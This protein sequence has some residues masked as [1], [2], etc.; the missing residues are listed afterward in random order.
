MSLGTK[1]H[2]D[3]DPDYHRDLNVRRKKTDQG[4]SCTNLA[5]SDGFW[6]S[7]ICVACLFGC[8]P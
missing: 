1:C 8:A 6:G 5:Y 4:S 3:W 7:E 2:C